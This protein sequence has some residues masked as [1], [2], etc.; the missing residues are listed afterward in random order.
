MKWA[1]AGAVYGVSGSGVLCRSASTAVIR[2]EERSAAGSVLE[3]FLG[4]EWVHSR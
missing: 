4:T 2:R 1:I 3:E